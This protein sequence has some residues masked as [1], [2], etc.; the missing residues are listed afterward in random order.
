MSSRRYE[1]A[2]GRTSPASEWE[3]LGDHVA[4][5][6]Q[7]GG[8][9]KSSLPRYFRKDDADIAMIMAGY[10]EA[11]MDFHSWSGDAESVFEIQNLAPPLCTFFA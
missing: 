6:L 10:G 3:S 5:P 8:P 7:A 9:L 11:R 4:G 1:L 2:R